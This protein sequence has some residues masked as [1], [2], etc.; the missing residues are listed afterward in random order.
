MHIVVC[1]AHVRRVGIGE[2]PFLG[3]YIYGIA[4]HHVVAACLQCRHTLAQYER[5]A[6]EVRWHIFHP[7]V[8]IVETNDVYCATL[9]QMIVGRWLV[10]SRRDWTCGVESFHYLCQVL[11]EQGVDAHLTFLGKC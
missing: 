7:L 11:C 8:M 9:K 3:C 10:T 4:W 6:G 2:P 1:R 5:L